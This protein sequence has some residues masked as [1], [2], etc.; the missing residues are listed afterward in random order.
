MEVAD[1]LSPVDDPD[2]TDADYRNDLI[3]FAEGTLKVMRDESG[4]WGSLIT[5][6]KQIEKFVQD[7]QQRSDDAIKGPPDDGG[8]PKGT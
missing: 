1:S 8:T 6:P 7:A 2:E 4:Q 3:A 5:T